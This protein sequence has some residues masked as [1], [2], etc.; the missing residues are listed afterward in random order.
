[1]GS[2]SGAK[3]W[4]EQRQ[5]EL[6]ARGKQVKEVVKTKREVSTAEEFFPR[7]SEGYAKAN[8]QKPSGVDSKESHFRNHLLP[9]FGKKRLD[10]LTD[11]DVQKLKAALQERSVKVDGHRPDARGGRAPQGGGRPRRFLRGG[12]LRAAG[13]SRR[14]AWSGAATRGAA[15]R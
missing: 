10:A 6:L 11:E 3:A 9:R 5:S 2:K 13:A 7:F 15:R 8:R 4:G 14:E 12:G 1:M